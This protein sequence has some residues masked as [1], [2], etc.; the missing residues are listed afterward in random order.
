MVA[1][2]RCSKPVHLLNLSKCLRHRSVQPQ[3]C[4][5]HRL[6]TEDLA[7]PEAVRGRFRGVQVWIGSADSSRETARYVPPP[8]E[9][10]PR[11][12]DEWLQW[13]H[14]QHWALRGQP[15]EGVVAGLAEL[16]HRFL[17]IHPF[18]DANGRVARSIAD[19]ATRELLNQRIGREFIE[20]TRAYYARWRRPTREIFK[21]LQDRIK[22]AFQ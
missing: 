18:I 17:T 21:P 6:L 10:V 22:A 1:R 19:Q 7:L 16:H 20:D 9:A 15:K 11:L 5:L 14:E 13:W 12:V 3:L 2:L 4:W 8:P